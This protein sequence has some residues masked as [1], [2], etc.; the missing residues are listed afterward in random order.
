MKLE[1]SRQIFEK[2]S[3]IKFHENPSCGR[4]VVPCGQTYMMNL[5]LAFRNSANAPKNSTNTIIIVKVKDVVKAYG[6]MEVQGHS[7]LTSA[8]YG[9]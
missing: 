4:R 3:N 1:F 2:S 9:G 8:L 7:F 5:I 6:E